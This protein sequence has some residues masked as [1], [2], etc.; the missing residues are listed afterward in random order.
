VG[1][2]LVGYLVER[3]SGMPFDQFCKQRLF[4]PL[5]MNHTAWFLKDLDSERIAMPTSYS[6]SLKQYINLG[7]GGYPDYPAGEL[8]TSVTEFAHFLITWTQDGKFNGRQIFNKSTIQKLTPVDFNLGFYTWFLFPTDKGQIIYTHT[9][10]DIGVRA[11]IG[12]SPRTKRGIII[13]M[14]GVIDKNDQFKKL[15]NLVYDNA[16]LSGKSN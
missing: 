8:R 15:I 3:I 16:G 2:A 5:K 9:G 10:G 6:D 1:I 12:F 14:N 4:V 11:F 13:L 7:Y